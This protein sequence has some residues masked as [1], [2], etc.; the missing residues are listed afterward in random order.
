MGDMLELGPA[1]TALHREAGR[2]AAAA[3]VQLLVGVGAR[4]RAAVEAA[5]RARIGEA[6]HEQDAA[7]AARSVPTRIGPGDLVVV[8]GSRGVHLELVVEAILRGREEAR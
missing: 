6:W 3:G 4:S 5:R 8:K 2:Q 7:S 1:E